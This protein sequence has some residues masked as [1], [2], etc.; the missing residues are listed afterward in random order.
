MRGIFPS[1]NGLD[2]G[3]VECDEGG[4]APVRYAGAKPRQGGE[5]TGGWTRDIAGIRPARKWQMS[6]G[7]GLD[8]EVA[9][10]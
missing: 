6:G 4:L 9:I 1:P 2:V 10:P 8:K 7:A 5:A 3:Q